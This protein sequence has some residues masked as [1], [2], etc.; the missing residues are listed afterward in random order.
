MKKSVRSRLLRGIVTALLIALLYWFLLPAFHIASPDL[1]LFVLLSLLLV[2]AGGILPRIA[3][4]LHRFAEAAAAP[5][6]GKAA[7]RAAGSKEPL[8]RWCKAL[9]WVLG[10][11]LAAALILALS[12][13]TLFHSARYK[14]LLT[15]K[16]G[17]FT[18]DIAELSMNQIPV[19]DRDTAEQLG[20][21]KLG[22]MADLVSQFEIAENYTQI[23]RNGRPVRVTPLVYGDIIKWFNNH[24]Q[25]LPAYIQV[26]MVTQEAKMV[27]LEEGMRYSPSELFLRNLKRYA[28]F[29]YPTKMFDENFSFEVDEDGT[30][31][32]IISTVRYRI[33]LWGGRDVEGAILINAV[34]G[35][36]RYYPAEEIPPWVDQVYHA[37]LIL[38]QLVYNGKFQSGFWNAHFGQRGVL[39]PTEGYNYIAV[40]DDVYLYTGM[41]SITGDRSNVGFV[42]VNMRTKETRF[43]AIPGAE[44]FSAMDS[45]EGQVQHLGY[46]A[47]FPLLLNIADRPTYFMALKDAAGLVKMYAFVDVERYQLVGTGD[48]LEE[49]RA[50]YVKALNREVG[51]G[52]GSET[53]TGVIQEIHSAVVE[54][55][56][57]Y[58]FR[59]EDGPAIYVAGIQVSEQLPFYQAGDTVT[60]TYAGEDIRE[61]VAL[62]LKAAK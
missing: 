37:D 46:T 45:A 42:L 61:V 33:G 8:P 21:R 59:L 50:G 24:G 52:T 20:K 47:T 7:A 34:T 14:D 57:R 55:N 9:L 54:G 5:A 40:N 11:L 58:Y 4:A 43:Y 2:L 1:W 36:H 38:E 51:E 49:T 35:E 17:D 29:Q 48:S 26:D 3:A 12:G 19:V 23:N 10:G 39:Q 15:T 13:A 44:E 18:A 16:D 60:V 56:T 6:K 27:R 30:P 62:Q 28:R 53:V 22:E 25:G 41:T 32:W 31:Y